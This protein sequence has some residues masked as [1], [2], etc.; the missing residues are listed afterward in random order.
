MSIWDYPPEYYVGGWDGNFPEGG[1]IFK[2][3]VWDSSVSKKQKA[4]NAK[5]LELCQKKESINIAKTH[6]ILQNVN[7]NEYN[8]YVP[9]MDIDLKDASHE[10]AESELNRRIKQQDSRIKELQKLVLPW[11]IM[12]DNDPVTIDALELWFTKYIHFFTKQ[13]ALV[14]IKENKVATCNPYYHRLPIV[15]YSIALDI[16]LYL[17]A[18]LRKKFPN[19]YWAVNKVRKEGDDLWYNRPVLKCTLSSDVYFF[20]E[21]HIWDL[22]RLLSDNYVLDFY[23]LSR[24]YKKNLTTCQ[25]MNVARKFT[26]PSI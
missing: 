13:E 11:G 25:R 9:V 8:H 14:H 21:G 2:K 15:W 22:I 24:E 6:W 26:T 10:V 7:L 23:W 12:L 17:S 5:M 1:S 4:I 3:F 20:Y 18:M 16:S 19:V